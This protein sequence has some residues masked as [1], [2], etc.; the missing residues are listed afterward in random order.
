MSTKLIV[1]E[2]EEA[3]PDHREEGNNGAE[4]DPG[5]W[6]IT[7]ISRDLQDDD[8]RIQ[9]GEDAVVLLWSSGAGTHGRNWR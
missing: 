1:T 8:D 9:R 7:T 2:Q 5:W 6:D 4:D 3:H